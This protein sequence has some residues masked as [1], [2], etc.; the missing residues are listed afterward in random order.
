MTDFMTPEQ[1]H[2]NMSRIRSSNTAPE[3][4]IRSLL[5]SVGYRYRIQPK[6]IPGR[7]DIWMRKYNTAIFVNGCFW[8][9]H[10]TCKYAYMPKSRIE[11]WQKKFSRNIE[12]DKEVRERLYES[13][14]RCLIIWEC[15]IRKMRKS[16]DYADDILY[17]IDEFLKSDTDYLEL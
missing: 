4:Y 6:Q 14:N 2:N 9:R 12:R 17:K 10:R 8:H 15:T 3:V 7:P 5:F 11:F 16:Q 1:R 13:K